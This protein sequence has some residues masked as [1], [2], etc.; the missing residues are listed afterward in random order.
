MPTK[1]QTPK[2]PAKEPPK[3]KKRPSYPN[4]ARYENRA[5]RPHSVTGG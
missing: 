3:P 4:R 2:T 1:K 5:N